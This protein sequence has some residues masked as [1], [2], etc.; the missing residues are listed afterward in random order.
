MV[1]ADDKISSAVIIDPAFL[2]DVVFDA[3]L[4]RALTTKN[5]SCKIGLVVRPPADAIARAIPGVNRVHIFDKRKKDRGWSGLS[6]MAQELA[7]ENYQLALIPHP[8]VRSTLLAR[9]A[10][11][12]DR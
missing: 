6:R 10:R 2:G 11:M 3:P 9:L 5:P 4:V 7:E 1:D 12:P 8:S